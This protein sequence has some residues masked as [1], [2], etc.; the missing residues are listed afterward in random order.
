MIPKFYTQLGILI[1]FGWNIYIMSIA[2]GGSTL[3]HTS[4]LNKSLYVP[5]LSY[6]QDKVIC[7]ICFLFESNVLSKF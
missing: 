5:L 7:V 2:N 6:P 3:L 4:H 1:I